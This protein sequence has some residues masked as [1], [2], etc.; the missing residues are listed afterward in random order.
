M[1]EELPYDEALDL[2]VEGDPRYSRQAYI[3]VQRAL[4]Y[5]RQRHGGGEGGHIRGPQL[6]RGVRELAIEEFGPLAR[7][8]LNSWGLRS[9]EDV[10][11]TVYNLIEAGL[12]SKTDEDEK[13]DFSGIMA[14]DET[15]DRESSW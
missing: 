10:G 15:L 13:D 7:S 11:E 6:L 9:G 1:N 3:F 12:M 2:V 5:Y 8:V 4:H 14:F